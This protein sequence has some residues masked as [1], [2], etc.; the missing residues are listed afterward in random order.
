MTR[1][2]NLHYAQ[3]EPVPILANRA[4]E[5]LSAECQ[6]KFQVILEHAQHT[7]KGGGANDLKR[8][9]RQ[10]QAL[11]ASYV[12]IDVKERFMSGEAGCSCRMETVIQESNSKAVAK[13]ST[14]CPLQ[15][16]AWHLILFHSLSRPG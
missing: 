7:S 6:Q 10:F 12:N 8:L 13:H 3:A 11:K 4:L 15:R 14:A 2:L 1:D 9:Q 5:D 16:G